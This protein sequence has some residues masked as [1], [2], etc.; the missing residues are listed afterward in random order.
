MNP[1]KHMGRLARVSL[2]LGRNHRP[3]GD[4]LYAPGACPKKGL[5]IVTR[6]PS[7]GSFPGR[8]SGSRDVGRL[9]Q[10]RPES[11]A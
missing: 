11:F 9:E 10:L 4:H 7:G 8:D 3:V 1:V 6:G 2:P 5:T